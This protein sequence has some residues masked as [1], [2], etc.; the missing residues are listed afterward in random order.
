MPNP[1][2][3][4]LAWEKTGYFPCGRKSFYDRERKTWS[5]RKQLTAYRASLV[6]PER[7]T[8]TGTIQGRLKALPIPNGYALDFSSLKYTGLAPEFFRDQT[9][10]FY[11]QSSG[12]TSFSIDFAKE[13]PPFVRHPQSEDREPMTTTPLSPVTEAVVAQA[14]ALAGSNPLQAAEFIRQHILKN[15]FYPAGGN[16]K[17]AQ[18]LQ[19]KLR[20]G[21]T[22]EN[23]LQNLDASEYLECYSATNL[24]V[25]MS[26]KAGLAT[27]VEV[28]HMLDDSNIKKGKALIDTSTGHAWAEIWD[29]SSWRRYDPTP[30]PK[31]ED[32]K[33]SKKSDGKGGEPSG[34][35]SQK[36]QDDGVEAPEG[37]KSDG[38]KGGQSG[39][40]DESQSAPS[41][42]EIRDRMGQHADQ[43][44]Q[45]STEALPEAT[46]TEMQT[47]E[48]ALDQAKETMQTME[49][50]QRELDRQ[51]K[52]SFK[53]LAD[54]KRQ[55]QQEDLLD[56]MKE[57]LEEAIDQ[58]ADQL[59]E[60]LKEK[61]DDLVE[62]GFME[63]ARRE[64]LERAL[65]QNDLDRLD[66]IKQEIDDESNLHE[67]YEAIRDEVMPH[68][69]EWYKIFAE[70]L[71][72]EDDFS[73]DEDTLIRA[74]RLN[75]R[76][77]QR[78]RNVLFGTVYNPRVLRPDVKPKFLSSIVLDVSGSM[79]GDKLRNAQKLLVFYCELFALISAEFGYIR[80]S[81]DVFSDHVRAVKAFD[82][83]YDS[84]ERYDF[85]GQSSTIK[86]RLMRVV[87]A[88]GGTNMLDAIR[89]AAE[90]LERET[91]NYPDYASAMQ[92][93][94]DGGDTCGNTDRIRRFF[95]A[96]REEGGF[97]DRHLHSAVFLGD[98]AQRR[99]LAEI[100]GD[101][102]TTV[103]GDFEE[104]IEKSMD[105]FGGQ[106]E[107][108]M[109]RF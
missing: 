49:E 76:S 40:Q 59:K 44:R 61:I 33:P 99:T 9:G 105:T 65:D 17:A 14:R 63:E 36:A 106:V 12:L 37:G 64:E 19:Y 66:K 68:V 90:N 34:G 70:M 45:Q 35:P 86:A 67:R 98:E 108:Y 54:Q 30:K 101:D 42:G 28:G 50:R 109:E 60:D 93:I 103:A 8:I 7:Q 73:L 46:D 31:P 43:M 27:R 83:N 20:T 5:K 71:P 55:L 89:G 23:Y 58:K 79:G 48:Q 11:V 39:G 84:A 29:E 77:V 18:A 4:H 47:S 62:E 24:F 85:G 10:C 94:G 15:H 91:W 1:L 52:E 87:E 3:A 82:Q 53:D 32:Q 2:R 88:S 102:H 22:G 26:R 57:A 92:F 75:R 16:P 25:A 74:G 100:F 97:G 78:Y 80:F 96:A 41:P 56:D 38:Q 107:E 69:E 21:S 6:A 95:E 81:I 104:L 13:V 51:T 72:R